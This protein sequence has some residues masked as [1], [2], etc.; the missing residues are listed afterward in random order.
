MI[1]IGIT[2]Q[3]GFIGNHLYNTI[4]LNKEDFQLVDFKK[5][6]F[7]SEATMDAFVKN[8]DVIVH[9]AALNRHD[10]DV[11]YETNVQLVRKLIESFVRTGCTPHVIFS[12]STQEENDNNYGASKKEGRQLLIDWSAQH[13]G[14]LTGM[15]IPNVF[16]P[17][18]KPDYN[19]FIATF[20]HRL[21]HGEKPE[22]KVDNHVKL[23]YVGH[24]V[25]EI[26]SC[27]KEKKYVH[28][29]IVPFSAEVKVSEV[30][31][32]LTS[33]R[34]LYIINGEI[35]AIESHFDL[36]LFN[37]FR[38]YIDHRN[39]FPQNLTLQADNRGFFVEVARFDSGGQASFSATLPG[40]TRGNHFHTRKIERF[41]VIRGKALIQLRKIGTDEVINFELDGDSPGYVDMPVWYTHNIK[42]V[43]NEVLYTIFWI[44]EPY[45]PE[46]ADTYF[47]EV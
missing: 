13:G 44:N 40:I 17:F 4:K 22:I 37:T 24:L 29:Y 28:Q 11:L 43:G 27:I 35:P 15:I 12:S 21:T 5:D 9:L 41:A 34:D 42:N 36:A 6:Y 47:E 19:S 30:L 38:S 31:K 8:C 26:I 18:G 23:I 46:N 20:C 33:F 32:K 45:D 2:G 25:D 3:N 39:Y 10:S 16:G 1:K 14:K 7:S